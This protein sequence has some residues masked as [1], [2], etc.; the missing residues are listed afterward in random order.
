M[1]KGVEFEDNLVKYINTHKIPVVTVSPYITTKTV[2][3]TI[4][5]M[6]AGIPL[7]HSAPVKNKKNNTT[8]WH[9]PCK[10]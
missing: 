1:G 10:T 6:K 8:T 7:I 4:A 3:K 9:R 5:L 2:K